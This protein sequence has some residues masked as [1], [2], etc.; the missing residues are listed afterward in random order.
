MHG[1]VT[2]KRSEIALLY[3]QKCLF[4]SKIREQEG[5]K[6]PVWGLAPVGG[7]KM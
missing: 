1:N 2:M 4:F 6:D 3:K 5:K 7:A